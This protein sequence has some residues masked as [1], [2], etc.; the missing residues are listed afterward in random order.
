[1]ETAF[2]RF[3]DKKRVRQEFG[4]EAGYPMDES[5]VQLFAALR[6][7]ENPRTMTSENFQRI[8]SEQSAQDSGEFPFRQTMGLAMIGLADNLKEI[9]SQQRPDGDSIHPDRLHVVGPLD[10][11]EFTQ[12][13]DISHL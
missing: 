10:L 2:G 3:F 8:V 9:D 7:I 6:G 4:D 11:G 13:F 5:S 12:R 1:M